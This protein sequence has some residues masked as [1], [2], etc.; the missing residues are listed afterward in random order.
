MTTT[1]GTLIPIK[2]CH[3]CREDYPVSQMKQGEFP[4]LNSWLCRKCLDN[5]LPSTIRRTKE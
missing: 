1:Y 3:W 2:P 4:A 5:F